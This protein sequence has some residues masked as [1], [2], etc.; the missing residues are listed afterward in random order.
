[1]ALALR[2]RYGE[3]VVLHT[4]DGDVLVWVNRSPFGDNI[5][6]QLCIDAPEAVGIARGELEGVARR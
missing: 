1:M 5:S 4:S 6:V 3:T 2:R